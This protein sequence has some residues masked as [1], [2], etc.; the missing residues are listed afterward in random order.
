MAMPKE[1]PKATPLMAKPKAIPKAARSTT[2][3]PK[4]PGSVVR[5]TIG[6]LGPQ[7]S[8]QPRLSNRSE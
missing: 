2:P 4:L 7:H 5:R 6:A 3:T 8:Q 1:L